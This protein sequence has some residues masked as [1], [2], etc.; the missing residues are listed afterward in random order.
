MV[1]D[2]Q[3]FAIC[4]GKVPMWVSRCWTPDRCDLLSAMAQGH[5]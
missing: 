3:N 5:P 4:F 1:V 2:K